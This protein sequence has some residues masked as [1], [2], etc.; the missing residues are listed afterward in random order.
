MREV[1]RGAREKEAQVEGS[2]R[3]MVEVRGG[4]MHEGGARQGKHAK[5][6]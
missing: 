5:W 3:K 1:A 4:E 2:L 6:F